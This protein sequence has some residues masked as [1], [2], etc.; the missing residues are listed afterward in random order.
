MEEASNGVSGV[1]GSGIGVLKGQHH[2]KVGGT[3]VP[4]MTF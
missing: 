1:Y 4:L 3:K 2:L